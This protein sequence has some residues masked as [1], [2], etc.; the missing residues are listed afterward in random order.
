MV[1]G[2]VGSAGSVGAVSADAD[3]PRPTLSSPTAATT[4]TSR[5]VMNP[6]PDMCPSPLSAALSRLVRRPTKSDISRISMLDRDAPA[7]FTQSREVIFF[8]V[9]RGEHSAPRVRQTR[10]AEL[11]LAA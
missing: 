5:R 1:T 3:V 2:D 11:V 9:V 10:G 6:V 4:A 7:D 8:T